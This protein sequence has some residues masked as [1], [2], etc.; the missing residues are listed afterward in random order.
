MGLHF[1]QAD[2]HMLYV[3]YTLSMSYPS[4]AGYWGIREI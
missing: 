2:D 1:F 3:L 4:W